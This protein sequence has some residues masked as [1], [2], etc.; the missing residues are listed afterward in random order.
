[1]SK[2]KSCKHKSLSQS[3]ILTPVKTDQLLSLALKL[4]TSQ[5]RSPYVKET[6]VVPENEPQDVD[7]FPYAYPTLCPFFT[8][9]IHRLLVDVVMEVANM[10]SPLC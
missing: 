1:M 5:T 9:Y 4:G 8:K 2:I 7:L 6:T 10:Y 3:D